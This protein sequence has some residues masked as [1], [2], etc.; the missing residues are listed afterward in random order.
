VA[1]KAKDRKLKREMHAK[2]SKMQG[3]LADMT[4]Q[5]N[6]QHI[7][8]HY[9]QGS[10]RGHPSSIQAQTQEMHSLGLGMAS[11]SSSNGGGDLGRAP[12]SAGTAEEMLA[13]GLKKTIAAASVASATETCLQ[14]QV[15]QD[16]CKTC[17]FCLW[18]SVYVRQQGPMDMFWQECPRN[19]ERLTAWF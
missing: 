17:V 7:T 5:N 15:P 3:P 10:I 8:L 1:R 9:H 16:G 6:T 2:V 18:L 11:S 12:D 4:W 14:T 19:S 13:D